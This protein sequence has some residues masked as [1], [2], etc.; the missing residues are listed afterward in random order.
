LDYGVADRTGRRCYLLHWAKK[1]YSERVH[2]SLEKVKAYFIP[3]FHLLL[4]TNSFASA[5]VQVELW[6]R[7][8]LG[9]SRSG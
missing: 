3:T 6:Q 5:W 7:H 8:F 4:R 9:E 1:V 2:R